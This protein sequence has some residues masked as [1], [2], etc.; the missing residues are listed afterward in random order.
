MAEWAVFA[1]IGLGFGAVYASLGMGVVVAYK[2]TGVINFAVGAMGMWGAYVCTELRQSGDLVF[3]VVGLPDRVHLG[4][5]VPLVLAV[6][7]GLGAS[8]LVGLAAHWL[9]FRRLAQ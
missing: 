8:A 4:D 3:P 1:I 2:G 6:G 7:L 9:V 5:E